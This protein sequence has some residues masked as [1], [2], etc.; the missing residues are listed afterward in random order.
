MGSAEVNILSALMS[1]LSDAK[2]TCPDCTSKRTLVWRRGACCLYRRGE[3]FFW[4]Y[5]NSHA[6]SD[7]MLASLY[8]S[9][10]DLMDE[11]LTWVDDPSVRPHV[12]D[13]IRKVVKKAKGEK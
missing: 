6:P 1:P 3:E 12:Q 5:G 10:A 2:F 11:L 8:A 7:E 13:C 9:F 4:Q